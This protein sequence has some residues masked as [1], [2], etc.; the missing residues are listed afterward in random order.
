MKVLFPILL[1]ALLASS[2]TKDTDFKN[3]DSENTFKV[4]LNIK[5]SVNN[6]FEPM[7]FNIYSK[8]DSTRSQYNALAG[9]G[10]YDSIVWKVS[11]MNGRLKIQEYTSN[12]G[13]QT[14]AWSQY[15]FLPGEYETYL[16]GYKENKI[17]YSDT[18]SFKISNNKDFLDFNWADM[19]EA[20]YYSGGYANF[21]SEDYNFETFRGVSHN[22]PSMYLAALADNQAHDKILFD[23]I[24]ALYGKPAYTT[25]DNGTLLKSYQDMFDW[26]QEKATPTTIWITPKSKI[27]LIKCNNGEFY[28][29]VIYAEPNNPDSK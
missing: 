7:E 8:D 24:T 14:I 11:N 26:H 23:Y 6:I 25:N 1:I 20:D 15:F 28:D 21:L 10:A 4:R 3:N 19:K 12:G 27:A 22:V 18:V 2:C 16:V 17:V 29:Y 13:R 9:A 5:E